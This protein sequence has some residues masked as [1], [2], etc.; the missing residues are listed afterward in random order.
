MAAASLLPSALGRTWSCPT[1]LQHLLPGLPRGAISE[2]TGPR[3]SGRTA[4]LHSLLAASTAAG[5]VSALV[6]CRN[7]FDPASAQ[8][9]GADLGKLLWVQ[10]SS[11]LD[12]AMKAS[13]WILHGGGFG[14]VVLDLCE[15]PPSALQ[16]IP[17]SYWYRFRQAIEN[18]PT[19]LVVAGSQPNAKSCAARRLELGQPRPA[20]LGRAPFHLLDGVRVQVSLR[21]PVH[22]EPVSV[23]AAAGDE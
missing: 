19:V 14:L 5:E 12:H 21:K 16:R 17:L 1:Y 22:P 8:R 15:T 11:R 10:C 13:D 7:S 6:D 3:S 4:L 23:W 9:A 20:W 2:I 18:T